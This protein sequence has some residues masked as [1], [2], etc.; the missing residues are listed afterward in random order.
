MRYK[1]AP[2]LEA[3][4]EFRWD[5]VMPLD[6][7]ASTLSFPAFAGF[8]PPTPRMRIDAA[9][10]IHTNSVSHNSQQLGFAVTQRDGSEVV[11]LEEQGFVFVQ[12][13]PYDRWDQ[14][15]GRALSLLKPTVAALEVHEFT[16]VGLRFIN[17]IDIPPAG[18]AGADSNDYVTIKFDGPRDDLGT[19]DEFQMRVV[20]PTK[21]KGVSYALIV[22]TTPS[23][24]PDHS[25]I[26]LD[27]AVFTKLPMPTNG[28]KLK[29]TLG[30]MRAEKNDI[31]EKCLTEKSRELFGGVEK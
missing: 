8:Q 22:A 27:I 23:P 31:F 1:K 9:I 18:D 3:V 24:L 16:Y 6:Q 14:F 4:L 25:A 7:L 5:S 10:D 17:R 15:S 21:K 19:I 30:D 13:A 20:K 2:I 12:R 11:F 28:K 26:L 29:K